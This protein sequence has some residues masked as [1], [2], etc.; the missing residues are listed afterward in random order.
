MRRIFAVIFFGLILSVSAFSEDKNYKNWNEVVDDM[1]A[2]LD[3]AFKIY[4]TRGAD[5]GKAQVNVAYYQY[6]EKIGFERTTQAKISG[7]RAGQ[8]EMQFSVLKKAMI[9]NKSLGDVKKETKKL[10]EMLR[11]DAIALD[12]K[13]YWGNVAEK[14]GKDLDAAYSLYR[15][16]QKTECSSKFDSIKEE[17]YSGEAKF[18][19]KMNK[20]ASKTKD[21]SVAERAAKIDSLFA[22]ARAAIDKALADGVGG[23]KIKAAFA[24]LSEAVAEA[25]PILDEYDATSGW[26]AFWLNFI[27]S[28]S[29]ILKEGFEAILIVGAILAYLVKSGKK[30]ECKSV[31]V[32]SLIG[33]GAS[34]VM[35][36]L[37]NALAGGQGDKQE[38]IEGLTMIIATG[39]L[40]YTS[41]WMVSKSDAHQWE[42]FIQSQVAETSEK[43]SVF[44]LSFTAFLAV[45]REGAE[46]VLFY[47]A[48]VLGASGESAI[49]AIWLGLAIGVVLLFGVYFLIRFVS[50]K[51]PL[52]PFFLGTSVIM[53]LMCVAFVG[54]GISEFVEGDF[55]NPHILHG[56]EWLTFDLLGI[57]PYVETLVAQFLFLIPVVVGF[58]L[59]LSK[60]KKAREDAQN[61]VRLSV[62]PKK[63][64][65]A[66]ALGVCLGY[67]GVSDFYLGRIGMA[68]LK[69]SLTVF[70]LFFAFIGNG[71]KADHPVFGKLFVVFG[72]LAVAVSLVWNAVDFIRCAMKKAK[73]GSSLPVLN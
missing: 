37:L 11:E 22:S 52:K 21:G 12:P 59:Q 51:L 67:L 15:K 31:Y 23:K 56:C 39:V 34:I 65:V 43:G 25:A 19:E 50:I 10:Q 61:N 29:I 16:E 14:L 62:S 1:T 27:A 26:G 13:P 49:R 28:I 70:G 72:L 20:V 64:G 6:Y 66:T 30:S 4:E 48:L 47:Q 8:V 18:L 9:D 36:A 57:H 46:I 44:G 2:V 73:D 3:E 38:L 41:N 33:V 42:G 7:N 63:R 55:V 17:F 58:V 5:E 60:M 32:G 35:A 54:S 45:F 68:V 53:L 24:E 40:F 71:A 69:Y